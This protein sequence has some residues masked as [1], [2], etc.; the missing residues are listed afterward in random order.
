MLHSSVKKAC[1]LVLVA[2][3]T[4]GANASSA[5][6]RLT[7]ARITGV[8]EKNCYYGSG[9]YSLGACRGGQKCVRGVN[10]ED[11]WED[12]QCGDQTQ[13]GFRQI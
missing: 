6:P 13:G 8:T 11:Y 12:G 5:K 7:G 1:L 9:V 3:L 2:G 4:L 10:N